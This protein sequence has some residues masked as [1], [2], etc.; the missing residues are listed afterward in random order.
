MRQFC[1]VCAGEV[2]E[3]QIAVLHLLAEGTISPKTPGC[4]GGVLRQ[5]AK[6]PP[7]VQPVDDFEV[8]KNGYFGIAAYGSKD[9]PAHK[10]A[11][12]AEAE[13]R[14]REPGAETVEA[15]KGCGVVEVEA[16][17]AGFCFRVLK[18]MP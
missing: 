14:E 12:V 11:A 9:R 16:E 4:G 10:E 7:V 13:T 8:F 5:E 1:G 17:S 2:V 15:Q 3:P 6:S 18:A